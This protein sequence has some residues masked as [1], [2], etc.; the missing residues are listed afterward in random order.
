MGSSSFNYHSVSGDYQ[1]E[2]MLMGPR[3]QRFWHLGKLLAFDFFIGEY[4]QNTESKSVVVEVGC[5]SGLLLQHLSK[6]KNTLYGVDINT[7]ALRFLN[8]K[9][10]ESGSKDNFMGIS[11]FGENL[12][13]RNNTVDF[14]LLS[15]VIEH[16]RNPQ[17]MIEEI[18]RVLKIGGGVYIT[19]PN[20]DSMWTW[21]EKAIDFLGKVPKMDDEQHITH[22]NCD[23]LSIL[24]GKWQIKRMGTFYHFSPWA[25][26]FSFPLAKK[27]LNREIKKKITNGMLL[28][29]FAKKI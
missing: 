2:A 16:L 13:F 15:E 11:A 3:M 23:K 28:F 14:V 27:I 18:S 17:K 8:S 20:Y 6:N 26:I 1:Y 19:T 12:P 22:F 29:C 5:G 25:S 4:F 24:L 21:V 10:I 7:T 9:M